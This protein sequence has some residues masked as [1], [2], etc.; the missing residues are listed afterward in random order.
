MPVTGEEAKRIGE[1]LNAKTGPCP[2]CAG[3]QFTVGGYSYV[4]A[5]SDPADYEVSGPVI[6]TVVAICN[7][8]GFIAEH[9]RDPLG[10]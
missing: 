5:K 9:A 8:C 6:G 4:H 7:T 3:R 1:V 10:L 2:R